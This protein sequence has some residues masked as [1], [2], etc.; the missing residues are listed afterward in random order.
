VQSEKLNSRLAIFMAEFKRVTCEIF[1]LESFI[2]SLTRL[3][4]E[5]VINFAAARDANQIVFYDTIFQA[6]IQLCG[7]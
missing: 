2:F 1:D 7:Q 5:S 3:G 4:V 6:P